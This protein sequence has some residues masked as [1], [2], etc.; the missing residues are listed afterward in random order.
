M[1]INEAMGDVDLVDDRG[2]LH[3]AIA[4]AIVGSIVGLTGCLVA[5]QSAIG[6]LPF[7]G[8]LSAAGGAI[9]GAIGGWVHWR[10]VGA[11]LGAAVLLLSAMACMSAILEPH[12]PRPWSLLVHAGII[13]YL[14]GGM[15]NV[16]SRGPT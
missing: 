10:F 16:F 2:P 15:G 6:P 1:M 4:G 12:E 5:F 7:I 8:G 11:L 3:V 13:G 14:A 9:A